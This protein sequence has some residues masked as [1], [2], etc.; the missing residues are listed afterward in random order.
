MSDGLEATLK[1][2]E[3]RLSITRVRVSRTIEGTGGSHTVEFV[4]DLKAASFG[5]ARMLYLVLSLR[6]D[7]AAYEVAL[8]G[9]IIS[10]EFYT[11]A[12]RSVKQEYA[13]LMQ[14]SLGESDV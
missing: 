7:L 2:V 9:G 1:R 11:D 13:L 10:P 8:A 4:S 3:D 12:V 5:E 6:T 14:R